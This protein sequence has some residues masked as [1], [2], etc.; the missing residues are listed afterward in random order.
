M[1][2]TRPE[3]KRAWEVRLSVSSRNEDEAR[4]VCGEHVGE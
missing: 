2:V 1:S 3:I 4:A